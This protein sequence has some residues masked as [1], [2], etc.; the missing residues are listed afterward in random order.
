MS[1]DYDDLPAVE[2]AGRLGRVG[3]PGIVDAYSASRA[4]IAGTELSSLHF[5]LGTQAV[6]FLEK[7]VFPSAA[8]MAALVS[9]AAGVSYTT[10][11]DCGGFHYGGGCNNPCF[12]YAPDH[13]STWYCAT[14]AKQA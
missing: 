14:C 6:G 7:K 9:P 3:S 4:G 5:S 8:H 11:S 2:S 12:G 10:Y 13:M 1:L